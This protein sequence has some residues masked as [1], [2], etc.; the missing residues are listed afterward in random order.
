[1]IESVFR[2]HTSADEGGV[3]PAT[4]IWWLG[5]RRRSTIA[6]AQGCPLSPLG[7]HTEAA[8]DLLAVA[9]AVYCADRSI[10]RE[11]HPDGW[12]RHIKVDVP[13]RRPD[14]WDNELLQRTVS[15]LTG[16][17]WRIRLRRGQPHPGLRTTDAVLPTVDSAALFSGGVDSLAW[18]CES[19]E[20]SESVAL[21]SYFDDGPTGHLQKQLISGLGSD[22]PHYRFRI[23]RTDTRDAAE[24]PDPQDRTTRSR[25]FL[26]L[27][28]GLL[29]ARTHG[30]EILRMAEN[31]YIAV[32][33]PLHDGRIGSLSTRSAHPQFVDDLNQV[34]TDTDL[35]VKID[36]PYILMTKG[37]VAERLMQHAPHLAWM[38][39]S[40]AHPTA[41]RW[42]R[43]GFGNCGYCYPCIIRQAGFHQVGSDKTAYSVDPFSDIGFYGKSS[44][45]SDI[46]SVAR[47]L[48]DPVEIGD[49]LATGRL[50]TFDFAERLHR[51]YSRGSRELSDLFA[52]RATA[53]VTQMLGL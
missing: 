43:Q 30:V 37:D 28:L 27:A 9:V 38:T 4:P 2:L 33:V 53:T 12:T 35:G 22:H 15:F 21:A 47:F 25:S 52:A 14:R 5:D 45:C 11:D 20:A 3:G 36:N 16:D 42:R 26:F 13:V 40:C 51:M 32:N 31:G 8:E 46:R 39:I 1:M 48:L 24:P 49:I 23:D 19:H 41:G 7:T 44:R 29:V 34:I 17:H 6:L 50:G 10:L 18:A